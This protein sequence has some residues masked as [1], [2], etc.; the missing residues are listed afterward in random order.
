MS[1]TVKITAG[2]EQNVR[3]AGRYDTKAEAITAAREMKCAGA[4]AYCVAVP[5]PPVR[6]ATLQLAGRIEVQTTAQLFAVLDDLDV[7]KTRL[8]AKHPEAQNVRMVAAA[9]SDVIT[10]REGIDDQLDAIFLDDDFAGTYTEA[11][12]RAIAMKAEAAK[13]LFAVWTPEDFAQT[14]RDANAARSNVVQL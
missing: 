12:R 6:M 11:M 9:V 2:S 13:P 7:L 1:Y 4:G 8:D 10:A 3:Y 14:V 5:A